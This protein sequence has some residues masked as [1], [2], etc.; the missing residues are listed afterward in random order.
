MRDTLQPV[1]LLE[2]PEHVDAVRQLTTEAFAASPFGHHGEADLITALREQSEHILSLVAIEDD[3]VIG[4]VLFSPA[5]ILGPNFAATG[6]GLAPMA[7]HPSHQRKGIGAALITEGLRRLDGLGNRFTIVAGHPEYY[8]RFGFRP[9]QEFSV[10]HGFQ[11][12]PQDV[13][14]LR[15]GPSQ[16]GDEFAGG[17]AHYHSAFG[18]QHEV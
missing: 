18:P 17:R 3:R 12:M 9:A 2:T 14:F 10:S 1:I 8:P 4:H 7:V 5:E 11:G 6:T 15:L 16:D 13:F